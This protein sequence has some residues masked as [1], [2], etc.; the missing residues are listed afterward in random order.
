MAM[1][2]Q[3]HR[4]WWQEENCNWPLMARKFSQVGLAKVTPHPA[5]KLDQLPTSW[6]IH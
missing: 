3:A 4:R 5:S 6:P 1:A 2:T